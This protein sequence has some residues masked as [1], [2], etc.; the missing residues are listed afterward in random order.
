MYTLRTFK[1]VKEI[2][3]TQ[4]YL[5]DAYTV[6]D[7]DEEDKRIGIKLRVYGH[8]DSHTKEGLAIHEDEYAFVMTQLGGT[9]ETLNRPSL[10]VEPSCNIVNDVAN[11]RNYAIEDVLEELKFGKPAA[12][13]NKLQECISI[14]TRTDAENSNI[15][16]GGM[17]P[18]N[19]ELLD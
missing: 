3:R 19:K 16:V 14:L 10:I 9:F 1:D 6:K 2:D 5:G 7:A 13:Q 11:I 15:E 17:Q 4:I 8:W 12:F 18:P